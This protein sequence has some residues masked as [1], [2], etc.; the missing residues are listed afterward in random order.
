[1]LLVALTAVLTLPATLAALVVRFG[2]RD[3]VHIRT[4]AKAGITLLFL[5]TG[6]AHFVI[7]AP[8]S[9]MIPPPIP[10]KTELVWITGVLE[11]LGAIGIWVRRYERLTGWCLMALVVAVFPANIYTAVTGV[12]IEGQS[13]DLSYLIV[14]VPFQIFL[15]VWIWAGTRRDVPG[16]GHQVTHHVGIA[17]ITH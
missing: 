5:T 10:F 3:P 9:Q 11:I 6:I 12:V 7:T 2:D 8:M 13:T 15:V 16:S 1:M 17:A 4:A 14:R